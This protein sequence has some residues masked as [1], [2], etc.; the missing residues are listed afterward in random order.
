M[1]MEKMI[2]YINRIL[3][4]WK[5]REFNCR[6]KWKSKNIIMDNDDFVIEPADDSQSRKKTRIHN[7]VGKKEL[8]ERLKHIRSFLTAVKHS[9]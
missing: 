6:N 3:N 9:F 7:T 4:L 5:F 1:E 8:I 2:P